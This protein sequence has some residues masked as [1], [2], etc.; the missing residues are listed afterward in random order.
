MDV[1]PLLPVPQGQS[2][3]ITWL[4][5]GSHSSFWREGKLDKS[6]VT[7]EVDGTNGGESFLRA[8]T[9]VDSHLETSSNGSN[10]LNP[11][12]RFDT[13]VSLELASFSAHPSFAQLPVHIYLKGASPIEWIFLTQPLLVLLPRLFDFAHR[14]ISGPQVEST[15]A[16]GRAVQHWPI[17]VERLC[18]MLA[19]LS[20]WSQ[21]GQLLILW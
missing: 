2:N 14:R 8:S 15:P 4:G 18:S 11:L 5:P 6:Y 12:T 17:A 13:Y 21:L 20:P 16:L 7:V 3:K 1:M 19:R 10:L 9:F